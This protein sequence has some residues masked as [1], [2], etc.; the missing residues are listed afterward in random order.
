[1]ARNAA[2][3]RLF[4]SLQAFELWEWRQR[5]HSRDNSMASHA[6][7][8]QHEHRC[9]PESEHIAFHGARMS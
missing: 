8:D 7:R 3:L 5:T 2:L 9:G 6:E 1:M 4:G